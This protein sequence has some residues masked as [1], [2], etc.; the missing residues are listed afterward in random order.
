MKT[1]AEAD[2]MLHCMQKRQEK[3]RRE[4]Q[5][6]AVLRVL[7]VSGSKGIDKHRIYHEVRHGHNRRPH[8]FARGLVDVENT[9]RRLERR[10]LVFVG[11]VTKGWYR[12]KLYRA[13]LPF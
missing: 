11:Y 1:L 8:L 4:L 7:P 5:Q 2:M 3:R 10:N 6:Q 12:R 9:L 13:T